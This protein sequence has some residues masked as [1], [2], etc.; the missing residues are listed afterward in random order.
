MQLS[1][2]SK[3]LL[4]LTLILTSTTLAYIILLSQIEP[5]KNNEPKINCD[6]SI[7]SL[8]QE[9]KISFEQ[10]DVCIRLLNA[11]KNLV[12]SLNDCNKNVQNLNNFS[13][14]CVY[15]AK[16]WEKRAEQM[17]QKVNECSSVLSMCNEELRECVIKDNALP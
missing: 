1:R 15:N 11:D 6:S 5:N 7:K 2:L 17:R 16:L 9:L 13:Q 3:A 12:D 10:Y 4:I 14:Q 8:E